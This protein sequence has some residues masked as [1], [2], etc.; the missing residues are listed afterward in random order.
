LPPSVGDAGVDCELD[1]PKIRQQHDER[2][3]GD[4]LCCHKI[5]R[6]ED[7]AAAYRK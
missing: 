2:A 4:I 3:R 5:W 1:G 6:K 7:A